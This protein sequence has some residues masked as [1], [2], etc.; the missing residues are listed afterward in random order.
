MTLNIFIPSRGRPDRARQTTAE[1]LKSAYIPFTVVRT[2]GDTTIYPEDYP[3]IFVEAAHISDKRQKIFEMFA[4]GGKFVMFDDDLAFK[5]V[6]S[7]GTT[8]DVSNRESI[9]HVVGLIEMYLDDYPM[10]GVASR[11]MIQAQPQPFNLNGGKM[12]AILG[13]NT[14]LFGPHPWPKANR[15][16]ACSDVDITMQLAYRGLSRLL[17]TEYCYVETTKHN[18]D[19]GCSIWRTPEVEV[20]SNVALADLWPDHVKLV[21]TD[22]PRVRISWKKI[23]EDGCLRKKRGEV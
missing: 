2:L 21:S 10:V 17:I 5:A 14:S 15:L 4:H 13:Y 8:F 19:G 16:R 7:D 1:L 6:R 18:G 23:Y 22:P 12:T 11:F 20:S 9:R 3:Q